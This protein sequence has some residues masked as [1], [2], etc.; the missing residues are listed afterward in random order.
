MGEQGATSSGAKKDAVEDLLGRLNL[1][2]EEAEEFVWE[3]E[4]PDPMEKAKWPAIAKVHMSRGFSPS[5]LYVHMCSAWNPTKEVPW[6]KIEDNLFTIQFG[7]LGDWNKQTMFMG[8]WLFRNNYA[9]LM[10]EYDGFQKP[11][12]IVLDKLAVWVRVMHLPDNYM[13]DPMIKGMCRP[14]GE[15]KEE[16]VKLLIGFAGEFARVRVKIDV[17]KKLYQFVS[18]TKDGKKQR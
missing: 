3:E 13:K 18:I 10:E 12:S 9:L 15:V 7:C 11:R 4:A 1:H 5:D 17:N 14:V 8:P 16:H 6:R 2:E